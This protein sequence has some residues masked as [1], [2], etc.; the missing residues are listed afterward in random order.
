MDLPSEYE[1]GS[2]SNPTMDPVCSRFD[3]VS[4][5]SGRGG[6]QNTRKHAMPPSCVLV[7][8]IVWRRS[9]GTRARDRRIAALVL[10]SRIVE[11]ADL[12]T[13]S[14]TDVRWDPYADRPS[15]TTSLRL[16]QRRT[17]V[18]V[19]L[20]H[21]VFCDVHVPGWRLCILPYHLGRDV[22][23]VGG[24][25]EARC[26]PIATVRSSSSTCVR[27]SCIES[28]PHVSV[29]G[30]SPPFSTSED[31]G[32]ASLSLPHPPFPRSCTPVRGGVSALPW[33]V[34]GGGVHLLLSPSPPFGRGEVP[35]CPRLRPRT[36][37][38]SP[39]FHPFRSP[40]SPSGRE[41]KGGCRG[42]ISDGREGGEGMQDHIA[43]RGS[44]ARPHPHPGP[45]PD[46]E[47]P[48]R[49]PPR[50]PRGARQGGGEGAGTV[51]R[52]P[53]PFPKGTS[54]PFE[55]DSVPLSN[56]PFDPFRGR[57]VPRSEDAIPRPP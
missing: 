3:V 6:M 47:T 48:L 14:A 42:G 35:R 1:T 4:A 5:G 46:E 20:R 12:A 29:G 53:S 21:V 44:H 56:P 34:E 18:P 15:P 13:P 31:G 32:V 7:S 40:P 52:S 51:V 38:T 33:G 41:R 23:S 30:P 28:G 54:S 43:P 10:G 37:G 49:A 16:L 55:P 27:W 8:S 26:A 39:F 50:P 19:S 22:L 17:V 36:R 9:Q 57:P 11:R 2:L 25:C 45:S 24:R